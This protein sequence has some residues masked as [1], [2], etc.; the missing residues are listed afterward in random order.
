MTNIR[1]PPIDFAKVR[2][3]KVDELGDQRLQRRMA[4]AANDA[5]E[6]EGV[7]EHE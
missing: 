6:R 1:K 5:R 7:T 4:E 2:R 3:V